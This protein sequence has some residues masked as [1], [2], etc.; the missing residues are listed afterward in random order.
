MTAVDDPRST[1]YW[2][3]AVIAARQ[4]IEDSGL[5]SRPEGDK[6]AEQVTERLLSDFLAIGEGGSRIVL[7]LDGNGPFCSWCGRMP[8]I[9]LARTHPQ[10]GV[11]CDCKRIDDNAAA[12]AV[13]REGEG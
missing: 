12:P 8:G 9:R 6:L 7:D 4:V 3:D 2:V 13:A 5:L 11:F 10:Y 1:L